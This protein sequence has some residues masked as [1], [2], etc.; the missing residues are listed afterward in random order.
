MITNMLHVNLLIIV[1]LANIVL[2]VQ[3][4]L[5]YHKFANADLRN[6]LLVRT[7][8]SIVPKNPKE[9][10]KPNENP[11]PEGHPKIKPKSGNLNIPEED[12]KNPEPKIKFEE[13]Q[14]KYQNL[15][16]S[17]QNLKS[18]GLALKF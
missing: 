13:L 14:Q 9:V 3:D 1:L 2:A 18:K 5:A 11:N 4:N 16:I 7:G 17:Y 10:T 15:K 8:R 12:G 6:D